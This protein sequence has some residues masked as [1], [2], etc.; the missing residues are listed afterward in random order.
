[1]RRRIL[2]CVAAAAGALVVLLVASPLLGQ[3]MAFTPPGTCKTCHPAKFRD[4]SKSLHAE[5]CTSPLV[6]FVYQQGLD[7]A[8]D[9]VKGMC[10]RCHAPAAFRN[11]TTDTSSTDFLAGVQCSVCHL[12]DA[13]NPPC[14]NGSY[15][16]CNDSLMRGCLLYPR[17]PH[18]TKFSG[19]HESSMLCATCH[20]LKNNTN[21]QIAATGMEWTSSP[22]G[23]Q[24]VPCQRCHMPVGTGVAAKGAA[25][26]DDIH[27]HGFLGSTSAD[28]RKRALKLALTAQREGNAVKA[29]VQATNAGAGHAVPSGMGPRSVVLTVALVDG[30]GKALDQKEFRYQR[31]PVDDNGQPSTIW[32]ATK[33]QC[34]TIMAGATVEHDVALAVP[35][36]AG[37]GLRVTAR[38]MYHWQPPELSQNEKLKG[39]VRGPALMTEAAAGL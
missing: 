11:E 29:H 30:Q 39:K 16:L 18:G 9:M 24:S 10:P 19:L 33:M 14:G 20:N 5:S 6:N 21:A 22:A 26:R 27:S 25:R 31:L 8:A 3:A 4:W 23:A 38:V 2:W 36:D 7:E 17:A 28:M 34:N 32:S 37:Q 12:I 15:V 13:V 35:A 1:M